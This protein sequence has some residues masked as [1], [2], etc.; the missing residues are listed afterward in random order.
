MNCVSSASTFLCD[1]ILK[2]SYHSRTTTTPETSH[3]S[4]NTNSKSPTPTCCSD[5]SSELW[6]VNAMACMAVTTSHD[7][8]GVSTSRVIEVLPALLPY[9]ND[10]TKPEGKVS[11][12]QIATVYTTSTTCPTRS[13]SAE[14]ALLSNSNKYN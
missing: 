14:P 1:E 2:C 13:W 7:C 4:R 11:L 3:T 6:A 12:R 10:K 8:A 5:S 9:T